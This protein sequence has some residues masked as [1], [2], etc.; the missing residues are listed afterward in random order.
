MWNDAVQ[1]DD[2]FDGPPNLMVLTQP[3]HQSWYVF[4]K[5]QGFEKPAFE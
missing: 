5:E 3:P 1:Q 2:G 4:V